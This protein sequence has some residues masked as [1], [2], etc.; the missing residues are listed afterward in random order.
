MHLAL[1]NRVVFNRRGG[2][3]QLNNDDIKRGKEK[4]T[5]QL[6]FGFYCLYKIGCQKTRVRQVSVKSLHR[7]QNTTMKTM[8]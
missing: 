2:K 3:Q 7:S 5:E 1:R 6:I 8:H 4:M